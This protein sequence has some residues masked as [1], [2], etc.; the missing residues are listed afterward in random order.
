MVTITIFVSNKGS[1][2]YMPDLGELRLARLWVYRISKFPSI[3]LATIL[4]VP[5]NKVQE[6]CGFIRRCPK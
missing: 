1:A 6:R 3:T 4:L 5:L 2:K